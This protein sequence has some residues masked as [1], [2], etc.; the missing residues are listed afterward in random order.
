MRYLKSKKNSRFLSFITLLSI[1]GVALGVT[2]MIVVLSVMDGFESELKKR[3]MGT[4]LHIL[5]TPTSL[6]EGFD[7][8]FV[9]KDSLDLASIQRRVRDRTE[10]DSFYP[11]VST[12]AILKVARK[13]SGVEVKSVTPERLEKMKSMIVERASPGANSRSRYPGIYIGQE[14]AYDMG[15]IVGDP[16]TLIS[17]TETEGPLSSVPR[18]KK[19]SVEGIYHSGVPEQELHTIFAQEQAIYSFLRRA[20]VISHWEMTVKD[21]DEAPRVASEIQAQAPGFKV[22]DW[23]QLNQNLF[24]SLKLERIS[25][26]VILAFIV[27]VASFNIVTT[28]TLMVLEKKREISILRAMGAR[29]GAVAAVFLAEGLLI[30]GVGIA[31]GT[32]L[33]FFLCIMLRRWDLIQLPDVFYDRTLPVTFDL[34]YYLGVSCCAAVI[35]LLA[36]L[37]PSKR[38]A[39]LEPLEGIR[40]G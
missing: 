13:V 18:L 24:W 10:I 40:F 20:G 21:F 22:Q 6:V 8:G 29:E 35:V 15:L 28:L 25:M 36:C 3:L 7:G 34:R 11:V 33:G 32:A 39:K 19:F 12:E 5:I 37:Y 17:P 27:V 2:A 31:G 1:L 30:G 38:A 9:P 16:V 14:L 4:D 23:I 26:F